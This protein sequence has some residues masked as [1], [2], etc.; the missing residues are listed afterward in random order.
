LKG[1][2][3]WIGESAI[4]ADPGT[5]ELNKEGRKGTEKQETSKK[6]N[7]TRKKKKTTAA[8]SSGRGKKGHH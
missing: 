2:R 1:G 5:P 7:T 6:G 4:C 3:D 8:I